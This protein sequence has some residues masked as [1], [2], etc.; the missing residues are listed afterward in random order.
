MATIT[1]NRTSA[2]LYNTRLNYVAQ[3]LN[4]LKGSAEAADLQ[5]SLNQNLD[6]MTSDKQS[7]ETRQQAAK[8]FL[9]NAIHANKDGKLSDAQLLDMRNLAE[10]FGVNVSTSYQDNSIIAVVAQTATEMSISQDQAYAM[11]QEI[12]DL[13]QAIGV[14]AYASLS[15]NDRSVLERITAGT[16][17]GLGADARRDLVGLTSSDAYASK[18]P[19]EK[20][21]AV[22]EF[23]KGQSW[24][25]ENSGL[26]A[27]QTVDS[28]RDAARKESSRVEL[29]QTQAD[30]DA[31]LQRYKVTIKADGG[32]VTVAVDISTKD[33]S[34]TLSIDEVQRALAQAPRVSLQS[35]KAVHAVEGDQFS[36]FY[37]GGNDR[38][39]TFQGTS[40][41]ANARDRVT[42]HEL[43]HAVDDMFTN[44]AGLAA[45]SFEQQWLSAMASDE[46]GVS[47]YGATNPA[48]DMA[49]A[50]RFYIESKGTPNEATA[51]ARWPERFAILDRI[52]S[53]GDLS[54]K[55]VPAT[56][57]A[58][59]T[60]GG[61]DSSGSGG[62]IQQFLDHMANSAPAASIAG[63]TD[64]SSASG[65]LRHFLDQMT[66][67]DRVPSEAG[68]LGGGSTTGSAEPISNTFD[69]LSQVLKG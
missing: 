18:T 19:A 14:E 41:S 39:F 22:S 51:R 59:S 67:T 15:Q 8:S 62:S 20:A 28:P 56:N 11:S 52:Y 34:K 40:P 35:V 27:A 6:V 24:L 38:S 63:E 69:K 58:V 21:I 44:H 66:K 36:A 17:L 25:K 37:R 29:P 31:Q 4:S 46:L 49:E 10:E 54:Q 45:G 50:Q 68:E 64:S 42:L 61:N 32:D 16:T 3:D 60:S 33:P 13:P 2:E 1:Q 9:D 30:K 43:G 26:D 53:G 57:P 5:Q 7:F 48:E 65:A 12:M 55:I 23:V 47:G